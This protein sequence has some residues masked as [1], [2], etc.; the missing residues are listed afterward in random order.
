MRRELTAWIALTVLGSVLVLWA[1]GR[2]WV[3]SSTAGPGVI[4]ASG[5][6]LS[7]VLTP[8]ALAVLAG[9]VAVLAT[10]GLARRLVGALVALCGAGAAVAAWRATDTVTVLD[11]VGGKITAWDTT[12][13]QWVA[14]LGGVLMAAAGVL[15][16][17]RGSRWTGMSGRYDR[18]GPREARQDDRSLWDALDRG[19]DPTSEEH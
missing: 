16:V 15:A 19:D 6:E 17:L 10:K 11:A 18:P 2:A 7:P 8:L 1:S 14:V 3:E 9:V 13:W 4:T 12:V 5:S